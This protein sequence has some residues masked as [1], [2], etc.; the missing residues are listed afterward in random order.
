MIARVLALYRPLLV[1][2]LIAAVAVGL[3]YAARSAESSS[4]ATNRSLLDPAETTGVIGDVSG[5]LARVL[6][7]T[8]TTLADTE[9]AAAEA[10]TGNAAK[11]YQQILAPVRAQAPAQRLSLTTRVVRAGVT[12]LEDDRARLLV[13]LDQQTA[14]AGAP[15]GDP[16][17]AQLTVTAR[18]T[19]GRWRITDIRSS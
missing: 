1:A 11:Q 13:F 19:D 12:T 10:L 16:A 8:P 9:K 3:N 15:V 14:R 7:Y 4:P 18:R 17:A 6:S 5:A 2:A